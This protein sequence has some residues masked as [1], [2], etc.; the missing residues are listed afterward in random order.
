MEG[1]SAMTIQDKAKSWAFSTGA[2]R[3]YPQ[4]V[5][6]TYTYSYTNKE[7]KRRVK[8]KHYVQLVIE[9]GNSR[10]VGKHQYE[11]EQQMTDK[12]SEIYVHYYLKA[13]P[14]ENS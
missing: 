5:I 10:H 7:G 13:H 1:L 12:V 2:L 14:N 11:Q 9:M 6:D 4:C 3:V 8:Q